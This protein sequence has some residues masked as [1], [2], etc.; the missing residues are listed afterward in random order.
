[1]YGIIR[2]YT[3]SSSLTRDDIEAFKRRIEENYVPKAQELSGFHS[4]TVLRA[5]KDMFT[6]SVFDSKESA[7]ESTV[8]AA[9]FVQQ[10]PIKDQVGK[11]EVIEGEV[12]VHRDAAVG[13]R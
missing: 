4:Y 3:P 11:P 12:L 7:T 6:V 9:K 10:D 2:R 5:G 13:V 8:R 1:M